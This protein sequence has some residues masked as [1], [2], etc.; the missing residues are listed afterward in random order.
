[1]SVAEVEVSTPYDED[2]LALAVRL[3]PIIAKMRAEGRFNV[4]QF[5]MAADAGMGGTVVLT[6]PS[7]RCKRAVPEARY[8]PE[9]IMISA[10]ASLLEAH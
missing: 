3:A 4:E 6:A 2:D 8:V 9:G 7:T 5:F 1:M 10:S